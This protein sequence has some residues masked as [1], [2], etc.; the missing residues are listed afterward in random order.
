[1]R[2][3]QGWSGLRD[4]PAGGVVHLDGHIPASIHGSDKW[5]ALGVQAVVVVPEA[6]Q[7]LGKEIGLIG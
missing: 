3:A 5:V 2:L 6:E 4:G 7:P 1:M